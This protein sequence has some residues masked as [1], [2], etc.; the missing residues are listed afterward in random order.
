M[1]KCSYAILRVHLFLCFKFD[2]IQFFLPS[3]STH[4]NNMKIT[5]NM[6]PEQVDA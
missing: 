3:Q 5:Y 4:T 1:N 2:Q 6:L